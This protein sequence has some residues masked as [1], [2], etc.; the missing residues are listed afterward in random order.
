MRGTLGINA[1]KGFHHNLA[2]SL[3]WRWNTGSTYGGF[4]P[5]TVTVDTATSGLTRPVSMLGM[6]P[7][8]IPTK[9]PDAAEGID[10]IFLHGDT[11]LTGGNDT[12]I[13]KWEVTCTPGLM[14]SFTDRANAKLTAQNIAAGKATVEITSHDTTIRID[15]L[16]YNNVPRTFPPEAE[17]FFDMYPQ[18]AD[19]TKRVHPLFVDF[20]RRFS[21]GMIRAMSPFGTNLG[22]S[23]GITYN[24]ITEL[25]DDSSISWWYTGG[26]SNYPVPVE[27]LIEIA[28]EAGM[29]PWYNLPQM[30]DTEA[31]VRE[32]AA[33]ALAAMPDDMAIYV[34]LGNELWNSGTFKQAGD[35]N[36]RAK[37]AGVVSS[38]QHAREVLQRMRWFRAVFDDAGQGHRVRPILAWQSTVDYA[39]WARMLSETHLPDGT[40]TNVPLWQDLHGVAI[41][42]YN[43]HALGYYDTTRQ[44]P[45]E[46]RDLLLSDPEAFKEKA[47]EALSGPMFSE[48]ASNW[49][50]FVSNVRSFAKSVG[51]PLNRFQLMCYEFAVQHIIVPDGSKGGPTAEYI[52]AARIAFAQMLRDPRMGEL[53]VRQIEIMRDVGADLVF[54][55]GPGAIDESTGSGMQYGKWSITNSL[56]DSTSEPGASI[57]HYLGN[58]PLRV[59]SPVTRGV[60]A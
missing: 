54:F 45:Q 24:S 40:D 17:F 59:C 29:K 13:G 30:A 42:P 5:P 33:N 7:K 51:Q 26:N 23:A 4:R 43:G 32:I 11:D 39:Q 20:Y 1:T 27:I 55:Q 25:P 58:P 35:L 50:A 21:G 28:A 15:F 22:Y 41:A 10:K 46:H 47:F 2:K 53:Q 18:G 44:F 16:G 37:A 57:F 36:S 6:T 48:M 31:V 56:V 8:G 34:E 60:L 49:C 19:K 38:V 52:S 14:W 3:Q 12:I 9:F